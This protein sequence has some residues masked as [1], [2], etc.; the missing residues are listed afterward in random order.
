MTLLGV[1]LISV[2]ILIYYYFENLDLLP[3]FWLF[4]NQNN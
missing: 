1:Q 4:D 3:K 2:Q